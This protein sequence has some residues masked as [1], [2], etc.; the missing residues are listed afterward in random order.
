[1]DSYRIISNNIT[2]IGLKDIRKSIVDCLKPKNVALTT[3]SLG[4]GYFAYK[5]VQ[6]YLIRRKYRHIPG[7]P[8]KGILGFYFGHLN[9]ATTA[10]RNGQILDSLFTEW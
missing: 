8:T 1:M 4:F 2:D 9:E 7:P 10:F 6:I 5:T 3:I